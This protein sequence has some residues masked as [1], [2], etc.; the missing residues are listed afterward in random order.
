MRPDLVAYAVI[1]S[2]L[3]ECMGAYDHLLRSQSLPRRYKKASFY[4]LR[5]VIAIGAG[6]LPGVFAAETASAAFALG[7]SAPLIINRLA[8]G[9]SED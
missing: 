4:V 3:A 2:L 8:K 1:G 5:G 7:V 9:F 6:V